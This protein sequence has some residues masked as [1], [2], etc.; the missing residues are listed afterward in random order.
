MGSQIFTDSNPYIKQNRTYVPV[1]FI[2]EAF[3]MEVEWIQEEKKAI[4]R[5]AEN[6]IELQIDSNMMVV[7]NEAVPMDVYVEGENGRT[8]VPV[9]FIEEILNFSVEWDDSTCSV[10]NDEEG[11][12]VPASSIIQRST[13]R[14]SSLACQDY[15][16]GRTK[17]E[18]EW[19]GCHC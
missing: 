9:R 13:P 14:G 1:R 2:A 10:A 15:S 6:T 17:S 5:D 19:K 4:L 12:E 7:N 11:A 3:Q 16:G 18:C 8:M